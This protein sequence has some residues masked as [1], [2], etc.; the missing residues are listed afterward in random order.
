MLRDRSVH[1]WRWVR[2]QMSAIPQ[3]LL[4][5]SIT[6]SHHQMA[7]PPISASMSREVTTLMVIRVLI[8][9]LQ[10]M[11]SWLMGQLQR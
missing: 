4:H 2:S 6:N 10:R 7:Q 3:Y 8:Y 1:S 9:V 5:V 11:P